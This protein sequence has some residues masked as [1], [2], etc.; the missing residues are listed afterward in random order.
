VSKERRGRAATLWLVL[1]VAGCVLAARGVAFAQQADERKIG[2]FAVDVH[3]VTG[4]YG[5]T[6]EQAASLGYAD[7]DLPGRGFGFDIGGQFYVMKIGKVTL[8]AGGN[9]VRTTGHSDPKDLE[10]FPTGNKANTQFRAFATQVTANFGRRRG[11]SYLSAGYGY[12][13]FSVLK[14]VDPAPADP[15]PADPAPTGL[16]KRT[17]INFGGGGK[18]FQ[19]EHIAFSFDVRFYMLAAQAATELVP[20]DGKQTRIVIGA[21]VSFR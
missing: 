7:T 17:T 10:G 18:W 6:P 9:M 1:L 15:A 2:R 3:G 14:P 8:G 20:A 12:S 13:T 19:K 11:W 21:G 4:S 16:P 5:P